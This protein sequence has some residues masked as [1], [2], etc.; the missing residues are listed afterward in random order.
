MGN[1]VQKLISNP[2]RAMR[3]PLRH[4]TIISIIWQITVFNIFCPWNCAGGHCLEFMKNWKI[5]SMNK[6]GFDSKSLTLSHIFAFLRDVCI[7]ISLFLHKS[8]KSSVSPSQSNSIYFYIEYIFIHVKSH[9]Y[10]EGIVGH[11]PGYVNFTEVIFRGC[12]QTE[13]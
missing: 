6:Q 9:T 3:Y 8:A 1:L 11:W 4:A 7:I 13:V 12:N 5:Y 10:R 2:V